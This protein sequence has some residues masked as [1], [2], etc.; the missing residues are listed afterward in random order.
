MNYNTI[1][2]SVCVFDI[3]DRYNIKSQ[4]FVTRS[5]NWIESCLD[6]LKLR[7][8]T[9]PKVHKTR[10]NNNRVLL[11]KFCKGID[12]VVL[13]NNPRIR[14]QY[15]ESMYIVDNDIELNRKGVFEGELLEENEIVDIDNNVELDSSFYSG[16]MPF[17]YRISNGWL[18]T[19][20]SFG[21]I[22]IK[23]KE[24]ET[25]FDSDLGLEFPVIPD[26][27]NVKESII[28]F[29]LKT[30]IMRGYVHP[31]LNFKD[32]DI[33]LNP[34]LGYQFYAPKARIYVARCNA[35]ARSKWIKPLASL[36]GKRKPIY[37]QNNIG[38][39]GYSTITPN[40][41]IV[42]PTFPKRIRIA[43]AQIFENPVTIEYVKNET[44]NIT[45]PVVS[46]FNY[47]FISIPKGDIMTVRNSLN[48][49]V[50][51]EFTK[52]GSDIEVGYFEND[53]YRMN[54]QFYTGSSNLF[55]LILT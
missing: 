17:F 13:D 21:T 30:I 40:I 31:L 34:A 41:P 54:N 44:I 37:I 39:D 4:D 50:T 52:I 3:I 6:D 51:S 23:Y 2:S 55:T 16:D 20:V 42:T 35:D 19:N 38:E 47:F 26:E 18:H 14:G 25:V 12:W 11:P 43:A 7:N 53:L 15:N 10:F 1:S 22:E 27:Y 8:N 29:I 46:G 45:V 28:C 48:M 33:T 32:R 5:P 36:F 24:L 9:I 49:N